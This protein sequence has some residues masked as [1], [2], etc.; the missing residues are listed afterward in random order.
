MKYIEWFKTIAF[1]LND[2]EPGHEFTRYPLTQL[3]A[4]YNAAMCLVY[5]YRPDLFTEWR[6]VEL[7][8]GKYQDTRG[9]CDQILSVAD[10]TDELGNVI[11]SISGSRKTSTTLP[12]NWKKPSC[13]VRPDAPN[14]YVVENVSIDSNMNGRFEVNPPVPCDVKAYVRVKC[15][16]G[17]CPLKEANLNAEFDS[18]CDMTTAAWYFVLARM[19]AGDR[20]SNAAARSVQN[21]H[22]MFFEILGVVQRQEDKIESPEEA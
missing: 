12:R 5:K 16:A 2:D 6:I 20:F 9:C 8:A 17:P 7:T 13:L 15:V 11:K 22:R 4:A 18:Q 21:N 1:A 3:V 10:Q 19:Q 14:G